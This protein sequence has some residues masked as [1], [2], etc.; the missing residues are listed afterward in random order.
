V[1]DSPITPVVAIPEL[2][3]VAGGLFLAWRLAASPAA[4]AQPAPRRLT[5]WPVSPANV[6]LF[7]FLVIA[8]GI[9][10][11]LATLKL[12]VRPSTGA[13]AILIIAGASFQAGMLAG[14]AAFGAIAGPMRPSPGEPRGV[15]RSGAATFL[16]VL[17]VIVVL[18]F[19]WDGALTLFHLPMEKQ[20]LV[21]L[22]AR[23][24][25]PLPRA[26]MVA[27]AVVVAP[28]TEELVFRAGLFRFLL[29]RTPR[30]VALTAPSLFWGCLHVNWKTLD[31]LS[32]LAQLVAMGVVFSMAY[33][34]TGRIGTTIVAHALFNLNTVAMILSGVVV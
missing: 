31:G 32:A 12:A 24:H 20:E 5:P 8:G 23:T 30:W 26:A 18:T 27:L 29:G 33:E 21:E 19:A 10:V 34:R 25:A 2:A 9:G 1:P 17:P 7:L 14:V 16:L 13:D 22:L 28:V 6:L 3:L 4:R 11:Q 15:V